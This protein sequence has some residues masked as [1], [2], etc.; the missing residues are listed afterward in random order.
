MPWFIESYALMLAHALVLGALLCVKSQ[1]RWQIAEVT[2][3]LNLVIALSLLGLSLAKGDLELSNNWLRASGMSLIVMVLISF[4]G[5]IVLRYARRNLAGDR[6][7]ARFLLWYLATL[8]AVSVTISANHLVIFGFSWAA[9]SLSLNQL[10]LF[11]PERPRAAL[12]AHKKFLSARLSEAL[13]FGAFALLFNQ[14]NS[15]DI[16]VI[17]AHYQSTMTIT[18]LD[19]LAALL[20]AMVALIKCAQL[21]LHGWLIQVVEAPTPVSALLHAGIINLGGFLLLLF[22]PLLSVAPIAQWL[23]L[24]VAGLSTVVATLVMMTRISIKV[25]LA[26]STIAQMG[27]M[28]LQCAL[29]LYELALLHLIAH[30]CYKAHAFLASGDA[31]NHFLRKRYVQVPLPSAL[32][33]AAAFACVVTVASLVIAVSGWPPVFSPWVLITIALTS[34]LTYHLNASNRRLKAQAFMVAGSGL[35]AY[36]FF[37]FVLAKLIP[38]TTPEFSLAADIWVST[39]F[40]V[41]FTVFLLLQN[42]AHL[43]T[44]RNWFISLN[45]GFYLDEWAT[46]FTLRLWPVAL[47]T[48]QGKYFDPKQQPLNPETSLFTQKVENTL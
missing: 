12:A 43:K 23:L 48:T 3:L 46:R 27:L 7:N 5:L 16:S 44:Q 10:L 4:I 11:Y 37:S 34:L 41:M 39:L 40:I 9:I 24:I 6:D 38:D 15:F 19:Q 45:A 1:K 14:H 29:G 36:S 21:P 8:L 2:L 22:S 32:S 42:A 20:I 31:V 35:L 25:R 30:S 28:L 17:L 18:G 47:P 26:W 33:W 13:L